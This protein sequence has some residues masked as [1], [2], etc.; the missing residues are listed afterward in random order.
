MIACS[1]KQQRT[2]LKN[3]KNLI[4]LQLKF[5]LKNNNMH[6]LWL[7]AQQSDFASYNT[8]LILG[9]AMINELLVKKVQLSFKWLRLFIFFFLHSFKSIIAFGQHF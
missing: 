5:H 4:N 2:Q 7:K 9:I 8:L 1:L 6:F 3:L